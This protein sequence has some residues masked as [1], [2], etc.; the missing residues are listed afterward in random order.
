M[1]LIM[2]HPFVKSFETGLRDDILASNLRP[3][4]RTSGKA[5]IDADT[6][7]RMALDDIAY[8]ESCTEVIPHEVLQTVV[9]SAKLQE[10]GTVNWISALSGDPATLA[11]V[12]S[13][14]GKPSVPET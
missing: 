6:L 8:T 3:T 2:V 11:S 9:C 4:L 12:M 5:N 10:K 13:D 7:S 1:S 14:G